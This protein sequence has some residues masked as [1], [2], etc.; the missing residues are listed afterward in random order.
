[1]VVLQRLELCVRSRFREAHKER[2]KGRGKTFLFQPCFGVEGQGSRRGAGGAP[3]YTRVVGARFVG[4]SVLCVV[5][6]V[7]YL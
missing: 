2:A 1:M 4:G 3:L 6:A 7:N 5:W